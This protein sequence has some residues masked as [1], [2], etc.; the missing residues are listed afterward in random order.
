[1]GIARSGLW[2]PAGRLIHVAITFETNF[3]NISHFRIREETIE[4]FHMEP[5]PPY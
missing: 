5:R 1:M 3:K 2:A 4:L